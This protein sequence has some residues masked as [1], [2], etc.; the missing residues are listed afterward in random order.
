[1]NR[2]FNKTVYYLFSLFILFFSSQTQLSAQSTEHTSSIQK[3]FAEFSERFVKGY[4]ALNMP[5]ME[6][7]YVAGMRHIKSADSI[8]IQLDFFMSVNAQLPGYKQQNSLRLNK[9]IVN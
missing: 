7:S 2:S 9:K 8:K 3:K 5:E 1:M 4:Q 6:L